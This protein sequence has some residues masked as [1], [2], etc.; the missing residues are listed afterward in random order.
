MEEQNS[1][2]E[3]VVPEEFHFDS[4]LSPLLGNQYT[5]AAVGTEYAVPLEI[6][7]DPTLWAAGLASVERSQ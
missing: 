2:M 4:H 7:F 1:L 5:A 6:E 3:L